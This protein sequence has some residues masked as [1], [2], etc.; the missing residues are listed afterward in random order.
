MEN[1][2]CEVVRLT[3]LIKDIEGRLEALKEKAN[4]MAFNK[5]PVIAELKEMSGFVKTPRRKNGYQ[6]RCKTCETARREK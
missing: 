2:W 5:V 4:F 1:Y 6:T 3:Y